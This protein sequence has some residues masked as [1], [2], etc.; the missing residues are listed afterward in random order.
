MELFFKLFEL[1]ASAKQ[2]SRRETEKKNF[3]MLKKEV[4]E[5]AAI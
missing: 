5:E 3:K 1:A 4:S 2:N